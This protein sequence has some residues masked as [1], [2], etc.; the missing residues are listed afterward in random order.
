MRT[1]YL[2]SAGV[3]RHKGMLKKLFHRVAQLM[4]IA[5]IAA[6]VTCQHYR[7]PHVWRCFWLTRRQK[8]I[9]AAAFG[10]KR[11]GQRWMED[12]GGVQRIAIACPQF[13]FHNP[14][15]AHS[16]STCVA[17]HAMLAPALIPIVL[18]DRPPKV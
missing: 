15:S 10:E 9:A 12:T 17:R 1:K 6:R 7:Q 5:L 3:G 8:P 11:K 4:P 16:I 2:R 18:S 14:P 13:N